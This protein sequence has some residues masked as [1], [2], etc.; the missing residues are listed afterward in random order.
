[1][2]SIHIL[3]VEDNE[4][5]ILLTTEAL[6]ESKIINKVTVIRDGKAA[7]D[8]FKALTDQEDRPGRRQAR[9]V[10]GAGR[11]AL[12]PLRR[13]PVR[14]LHRRQRPHDHVRRGAQGASRP[15]G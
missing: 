6:E 5:D 15:A 7:I 14:P 3:L 2:K 11:Q 13:R 9:D 1:M 10:R 12:E 8:F 4:G